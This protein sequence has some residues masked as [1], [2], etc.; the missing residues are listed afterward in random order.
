[1]ASAEKLERLTSVLF[2]NLSMSG[3]VKGDSTETTEQ[4]LRRLLKRMRLNDQDAELWLGM[5]RKMNWK[6][7]HENNG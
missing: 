3:Y 4:K 6:L 1:M 7:K 5:F 2:E